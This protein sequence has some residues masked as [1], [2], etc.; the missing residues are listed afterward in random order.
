[1][2]KKIALLIVLAWPLAG[3]AAAPS[4]GGAYWKEANVNLDDRASLHRGARLFVNYCMGC[5]AA[6]YHRWMHVADDLGLP[7]EVVQENLIWTADLQGQKD[8]VGEL[9]TI[10]MTEEYGARIYG[11]APPDLTLTTRA[12]GRDWVYNFLRTFYLSED[13][14]T[15]VNNAV[16]DGAAMPH[17]LW[18]LQGFQEPVYAEG[19]ED[20]D[21]P[22]IIGFEVVREGSMSAAE[23]DRAVNDIVTFM[24]YLAEPA[25]L[26]RTK[27]GGWVILFLV[28]FTFLA[29]LLKK[30]YWRDVH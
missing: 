9:M 21:S 12:K 22:Q 14:P 19:T 1:M 16:L 8:A 13:S 25:A 24:A 7:E 17:I 28:I 15:G 26:V 2:M 6:Q 27:I 20:D 30:E 29:W 5:H 23:Y 10:A 11:Q 3:I 18:P 4:G